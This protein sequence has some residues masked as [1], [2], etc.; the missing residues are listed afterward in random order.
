M[1]SLLPILPA[2]QALSEAPVYKASEYNYFLEQE[3]VVWGVNFR[4]TAFVKLTP[5]QYARVKGLLAGETVS[6]GGEDLKKLKTDLV[7]GQFLV[8]ANFDELEVLKV[9]NR[10]NRFS[11][12]GI[13]LVIAPTLRCNFGCEY[14]Y[15]DLNANKMSREERE[16]VKKFF[17]RKMADN[18]GASIVW[19]GGDP[20]LAMDVVEDLSV[21]FVETCRRKSCTY[22]AALITNAYLLNEGMKGELKRS[23]IQSLQVS[24]DGSREFHDVSRHLPDKR[25]TYDR[26]MENVAGACDDFDIYLRINVDRKNHDAI[27]ELLKDIEDRGLKERVFIYF[28]H[29]DDVNENSSAY[30]S[31][32]LTPQEFAKAQAALVRDCTAA[33]FRLGGRVLTRPVN[34]F[35][36]ANSTN[37]YVIDSKA[38]LLKCYHDLGNADT[39]GVGRIGDNGEEIITNQANLVKWLGWDPFEIDECR[40]CKVLPLC[41]GGCS[42]KIMASGLDIDRGCLALRFTMEDIVEIVGERLSK[43]PGGTQLGCSSCAAATA[44]NV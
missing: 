23:S 3:G 26:I 18:T 24:L 16:R 37:Y 13:G 38:N 41:M 32:C 33:G 12:Q 8:P 20:S 6:D 10:L 1:S 27:P 2:K 39:K 42:H 43:R 35:C 9:K 19:T 21:H 34:T 36:G 5:E 31:H 44:M 29:V 14:C 17:D 28:A 40:T 30:G 25:P 11:G 7:R 4:S 22:E 15:V